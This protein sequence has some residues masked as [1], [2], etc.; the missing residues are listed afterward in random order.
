MWNIARF[1]RLGLCQLVTKRDE[2]ILRVLHSQ[3][4]LKTYYRYENC[5]VV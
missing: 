2:T 4:R 3:R 5:I 1:G